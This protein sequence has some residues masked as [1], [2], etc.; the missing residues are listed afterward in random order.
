MN[1]YSALL[2]SS[3]LYTAEK[4]HAPLFFTE[5]HLQAIWFE[6]KYFKNLK[7]TDGKLIEILSPGIWNVEAGPDF[8]KA[9]IK[10]EEHELRGDIEI[11]LSEDSWYHHQHHLD[12]RYNRVIL[13]I[14]FWETYKRPILTKNGNQVTCAFLEN[15]LTIPETRIVQL[16]DLDLYPYKRFVGSGKCAHTLFRTLPN[17][18]I[19]HFFKEAA[20]WRLLQKK[21]FLQ[22]KAEDVSEQ[23]AAGIAMALG[24]KHNAEAFLDLFLKLRFKSRH[25]ETI[26]IAFSMETCGFFE[27]PY[28]SKWS[29]SQRYRD[30]QALAAQ[31]TIEKQE[32]LKLVLHQIRPLNHPI[33]RLVF[34]SKLMS[35]PNRTLIYHRMLE[36]WKN[37]GMQA[38]RL[39]QWET[40]R[41]QLQQMLPDYQD[42]YWNSHYLFEQKTQ[43]DIL[44][45]MGE[46]LKNEVIVNAF[47]PLL[48]SD[49]ESRGER[50]EMEAFQSFYDHF[51][52]SKTSKIKYL[53]HRFFGDTPKG[54][55]IRKANMEQGAYQLHRDFCLHFEAS[56]QGCPFVDNYKTS[57][58]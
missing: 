50:H 2:P 53:I 30:L 46:N 23:L 17:E 9:H 54:E 22:A 56:C 38:H 32:K 28:L 51:P 35:D 31:M 6:Q 20:N 5:R 8:Q 7:S 48:R 1:T 16:I 42:P 12:E 57:F 33:R 58:Q 39:H 29:E 47:L 49:I 43:T 15:C 14:V 18:K 36:Y 41:Q 10:I 26:L 11:H 37:F 21:N 34:L 27:E 45:L 13:H 40:L 52:P 4:S 55:L 3:A 44:P 24:Y 19:T 25:D